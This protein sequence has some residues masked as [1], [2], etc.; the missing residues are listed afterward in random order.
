VQYLRERG[1]RM[2]TDRQCVLVDCI[3]SLVED[4][5]FLNDKEDVVDVDAIVARYQPIIDILDTKGANVRSTIYGKG[6]ARG[7]AWNDLRP[8][9]RVWWVRAPLRGGTAL[10]AGTLATHSLLFIR[11]G[12][13]TDADGAEV[14]VLEKVDEGPAGR[15]P[16]GVRCSF[17]FAQRV[18]LLRCPLL[19]DA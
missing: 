9:T 2:S 6:G 10:L 4:A 18:D 11:V 17:P 5:K 12:L 8:I 14:Y 1:A 3:K 16:N 7:K 13:P 19:L 15:N